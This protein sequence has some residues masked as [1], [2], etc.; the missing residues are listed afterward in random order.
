[1]KAMVLSAGYG[2]R[3]GELTAEIPKPMLQVNGR[4]LLEYIL[5]NLHRAGIDEVV[6]NL[7]FKP[8]LIRGHFGDGR[9]W[10]MKLAYSEEAALLGTAGGLKNVE[11]YF[12]DQD[13]F[14]VH[15]GD[16]ITDQDFRPMREFHRDRKAL[17]TLLVHERSRSNS[18]VTIDSENRIVNFLERPDDTA[19]QGASSGW[20]NSGVC[21]CSRE[22]LSLIPVGTASD[23]PRDIFPRLVASRRFFA[24]P[25]SGYRV[26]V[27]SPDRLTE[28]VLAI[29]EGRC[30]VPFTNS[31]SPE[32]RA[33]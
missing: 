10:R 6:I 25:L 23:F 19:R 13:D 15:Y 17:A 21:I 20:V 26:A 14:L 1:M 2:T 3:L 8:E 28:A 9:P 11:G 4:P 12:V 33:S 32:G 7:H 31:P 22:V 27:D 5:V 30:R 16:I 29:A 24:F 18:I